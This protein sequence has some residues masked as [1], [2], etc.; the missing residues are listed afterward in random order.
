MLAAKV[1]TRARAEVRDERRERAR[2]DE[3]VSWRTT[4]G[5]DMTGLGVVSFVR[6][7]AE[8]KA[9]LTDPKPKTVPVFAE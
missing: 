7:G 6:D 1:G 2:E 5:I 8:T 3:A 4:R 9:P